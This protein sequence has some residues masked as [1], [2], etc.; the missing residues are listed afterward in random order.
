[1]EEEKK[2]IWLDKKEFLSKSSDCEHTWILK[3]L[4]YTGIYKFKDCSEY[5]KNKNNKFISPDKKQIY[6]N[7]C[8]MAWLEPRW[9]HPLMW[10][11]AIFVVTIAVIQEAFKIIK[12]ISI[13]SKELTAEI[14]VHKRLQTEES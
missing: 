8:Y 2:Y 6:S 10:V 13:S 3:F 5:A 9:Y 7:F 14:H 12:S 11:F 4:Y 1:M